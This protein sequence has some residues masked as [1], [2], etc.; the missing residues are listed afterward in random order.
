MKAQGSV[1]VNLIGKALNVVRVALFSISLM[2]A[3]NYNIIDE[4]S[5][6]YLLYLP[7]PPSLCRLPNSV[8]RSIFT[9]V[10]IVHRCRCSLNTK[11]FHVTDSLVVVMVGNKLENKNGCDLISC[12]FSLVRLTKMKNY[13]I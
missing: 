12:G 3:T 7:Q 2:L 10:D 6:V 4:S 9:G 1:E 11:S 8:A 13:E 5:N